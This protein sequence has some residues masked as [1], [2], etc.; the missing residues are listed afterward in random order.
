[1]AWAVLNGLRRHDEHQATK[2]MLTQ[3]TQS[4]YSGV[5]E[6]AREALTR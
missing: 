6:A 2:K 5:A 1:M 4:P 3:L